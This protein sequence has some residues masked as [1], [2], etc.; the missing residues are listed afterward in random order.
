MQKRI[1]YPLSYSLQKTN[2]PLIAVDINGNYLCFLL[3]TGSNKN[4]IDQRVY[5][6][7]KE[8]F[9]TVG[10]NS[11]FGLDGYKTETPVIKLSFNFENYSYSTKFSVFE[12]EKSFEAIEKESDI[13]IHGILGNEFFIENGWIIDFEKLTLYSS[14]QS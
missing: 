13:Q 1:S 7:F 14:K 12:L 9:E 8:H 2:L 11:I 4:L 3:D 6:Y 10:N 5:E